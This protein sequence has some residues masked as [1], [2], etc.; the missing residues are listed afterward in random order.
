MSRWIRLSRA[1]VRAL[2]SRLAMRMDPAGYARSLGVQLGADVHFYEM[3]PGMFSTEPWLIRL[4]SHVH[5]T[6][7]VQFVT[8][9]GG[10]LVLR[11]R[12]P[13]L[14]VT[15]PIAVGDRVYI[16]M[17]SIILPGVTIGD[18]VVIGAGS[19][20]SKSVPSGAVAAGVP[21]KVIK[22]LDEYHFSLLEKSL[23]FGHLSASDKE[24]ALRLH[25]RSFIEGD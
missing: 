24:A 13:D 17:N 25:F 19:V 18:D 4:G 8:H 7:G 16:G 11:H 23:G 22:S 14:E 2:R 10:T 3:R 5:V 21:A 9:D 20:V 12:T 6:S 15:A 1:V